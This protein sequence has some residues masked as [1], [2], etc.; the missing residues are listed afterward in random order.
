MSWFRQSRASRGVGQAVLMGM[1]AV[2][3]CF[4]VVQVTDQAVRLWQEGWFTNSTD[5]SGVSAMRNP[6]V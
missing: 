6:K 2:S 1:H 5:Y 3:A 4:S